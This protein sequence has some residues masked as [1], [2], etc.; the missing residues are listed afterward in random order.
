MRSNRSCLV[1][2]VLLTPVWAHASG[3]NYDVSVGATAA[4][5]RVR[6]TS[7]STAST[8]SVESA[9]KSASVTSIRD[10]L[11]ALLG[12]PPKDEH[13][14]GWHIMAAKTGG[15]GKVWAAAIDVTGHI[16]PKITD[17]AGDTK[18][19]QQVTFMIGPR[20]EAPQ[21]LG[22]MRVMLHAFPFGFR[23]DNQTG[24]T[25]ASVTAV[26]LTAMFKFHYDDDHESGWGTGVVY[27]HLFIWNQHPQDRLSAIATF[28]IA[29]H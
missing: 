5:A 1:V 10:L 21:K 20:W 26:G 22:K 24:S 19:F 29:N 9:G 12:G 23:F 11:D 27:D 14:Y 13:A 4:G 25:T 2:A 15:K 28:R 3:H 8:A 17:A 18:R 6:G 7:S 16:G